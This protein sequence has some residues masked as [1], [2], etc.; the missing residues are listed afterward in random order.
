LS[1]EFVEAA[2]RRNLPVHA[3]TINE[4]ADMKRFIEFGID[5][6]ITDYPD[7]LLRLLER[8]SGVRRKNRK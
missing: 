4:E 5:G 1:K 6:L 3:W 7:R 2:H 8:G